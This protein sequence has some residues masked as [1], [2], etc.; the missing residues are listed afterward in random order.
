[1]KRKLAL[2]HWMPL[3][4][5]PP[6][7]NLA[8]ELAAQ[9]W[10]VTVFTTRNRHGLDDFSA[11]GVTV[12]R[13]NSTSRDE[14]AARAFAYGGFHF[15]TAAKLIS[16]RPDAVIY[17]EPQSS[18]PVYLAGIARPGM[19]VFIHHHEY[20]EPAE[21]LKPGMRLA[22]I[23]HNI[24]K[25]V[26]FPRAVWIS[27]TN[28]ARL[29]LFLADNPVGLREKARILPNM[30]P[31][32]WGSE[33]NRAWSNSPSGPLRMVYVGS[34]SREDT[35]IESC[36]RWIQRQPDNSVTLDIYAYNADDDTREFLQGLNTD[37]IR[38][39]PEGARYDD[40]PQLLRGFHTGLI[41]YRAR[42][43]NFRHNASNKLF[44]YLA[45]GL[46]VVF[47]APM[48]GVKQYERSNE[49]P[50]V[51][52]VDFDSDTTSVAILLNRGDL[53]QAKPEA[54]ASEALSDLL[55]AMAVAVANPR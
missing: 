41:L 31:A 9:G 20:H 11:P 54:S 17:F 44:E 16:N 50:R 47:P 38:F 3:E 46:D 1:M 55:A 30:P 53:P 32:S 28:A 14:G 39:H 45:C 13:S 35:Y 52:Q 33:P 21:F 36:V 43:A 6:A 10:D 23:F 4:M 24:E 19:P 7:V 27:H 49:T 22:R 5:Y 12:S 42:T 29:E 40:L 34:L 8:R 25:K 51:I 15:R 48:L 37:A 2:V 18:L 26:L